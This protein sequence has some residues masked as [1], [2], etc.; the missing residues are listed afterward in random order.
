MKKGII[1]LLLPIMTLL[2]V[3][4]ISVSHA[5]EDNALNEQI[6]TNFTKELKGNVILSAN[7]TFN[8]QSALKN[9]QIED[10]VDSTHRTNRLIYENSVI[11][12]THI[13]KKL[14]GDASEIGNAVENYL[15]ISNTIESRDIVDSSN[16][17]IKFDSYY[18][19]PFTKLS[20]LTN[21]QI[22]SYFD[23]SKNG[24]DF[25]L[26]ANELGYGILSEPLL[27]FYFDY[28]SFIWDSSYVRSIEDL[29]LKLDSEGNLQHI[30]FTKIKKDIFGGIS[31]AYDIDVRTST[32]SEFELKPLK[33]LMSADQEEIFANKLTAIQ[34]LLNQGNFTQNITIRPYG[35]SSAISYNNYYALND[36]LLPGMI[37]SFPLED[38]SYGET[39][40]GMFK[41]SDTEKTYNS[42]G[43]SPDSDYYGSISDL[44]TGEMKKVVPTL[45]KISADFFTYNEHLNEYSFDFSDFIFDDTHFCST[46]LI[47]IFGVVDP[48]VHNLGLY[49]YDGSSYYFTNLKF[50]FNDD[51]T[52]SGDLYYNYY[53]TSYVCTFEFSDFGSTT[54]QDKADISKVVDY[55]LG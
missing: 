15:S 19:S 23:I 28:D 11:Q 26:T 8:Y 25:I 38:N 22:N 18:S 35:S 21:A 34:E 39:Y 5:I 47:S 54:F 31:E 43:I 41:N 17:G 30:G 44:E 49:T 1:F 46:L 33:S 37:S 55:I 7:I 2:N 12:E 24:D 36:T 20:K 50:R 40:I 45:S 29:V 6:T 13:A 9:L 52:L 4:N 32:V 14:T 10:E 48:S 42:Y 27:K 3:E 51:N 53:G 16:A